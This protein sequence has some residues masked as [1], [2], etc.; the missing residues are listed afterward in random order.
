VKKHGEHGLV[1][2]AG[3]NELSLP[4]AVFYILTGLAEIGKQATKQP[5]LA[6]FC[7]RCVLIDKMVRASDD[8]RLSKAIL[9]LN[10]EI[11]NSYYK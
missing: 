1:S 2:V 7:Y 3:M 11:T 8:M 6:S 10:R 9:K 4:S 5:K